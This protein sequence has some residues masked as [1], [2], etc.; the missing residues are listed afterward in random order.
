[1]K[2]KKQLALLCAAL[3]LAA[4]IV[5]TSLGAVQVRA[6]DYETKLAAAHLMQ[7]WMDEVKSYKVEAGLLLVP[8]DIHQTGMIGEAYTPI[9][10][11]HGAIEAKR[12]TAGPDMAALMVQLLGEAGIGPGDTVGAGFSGSFP[13]MNLAV[14]AACQTMG[15]RCVYIASVG[16]STYGANQPECTFPDMV[17]RLYRDGL[18]EQPPA[19]V[20]PGGADDCGLDMDG[21]LREQ[22]LGRIAGYGVEILRE[23]DFETN[24]QIRMELYQREGPIQC[25]IGVGGNLTTTGAGGQEVDCGLLPGGTI[26]AVDKNSGLLQRYNHQGLPVIHLLNIKKL[27]ADYGLPYDPESRPVIGESQVYFAVA[28]PKLPGLICLAGAAAALWAGFRKTKKGGGEK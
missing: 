5:M 10:T 13:G 21:E 2:R 8:E 17:C 26:R 24:L 25:F 19:L 27:T 7:N 12:T 23:S 15:V 6:E 4:G 14:L 28:E 22:V 9:T 20:T 11:T 16:A 3:W 18:L 1:M